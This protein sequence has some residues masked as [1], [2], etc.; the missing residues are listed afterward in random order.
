MVLPGCCRLRKSNIL[1]LQVYGLRLKLTFPCLICRLVNYSLFERSA[2]ASY[3]LI[4]ADLSTICIL[5]ETSED[6]CSLRG[7]REGIICGV[8]PPNFTGVPPSVLILPLTNVAVVLS[9]L[10]AS[11]GRTFRL[12]TNFSSSLRNSCHFVSCANVSLAYFCDRLK[13]GK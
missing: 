11:V 2:W 8:P 9:A 7:G 10:T 5:G 1:V 3:I 6:T 12:S 4:S 13:Q